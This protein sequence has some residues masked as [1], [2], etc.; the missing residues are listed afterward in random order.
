MFYN[1]I[2]VFFCYIMINFYF[3]FKISSK[4]NNSFIA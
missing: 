1:V 4:F 3:E 2:S